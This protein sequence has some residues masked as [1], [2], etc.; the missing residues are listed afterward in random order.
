MR[1]L[2][3]QKLR[4]FSTGESVYGYKSHPVGEL[5][6]NKKGQP[7]YEGMIH[8]IYEEEAAVVRRIYSDFIGGKSINA[9]AQN[10]NENRI[11]T[12]KKLT[13]G[14]NTSTVSRIL[15]NE[16]YTGQC[17]VENG[18]LIEMKP[19]YMAYTNIQTLALL[20]ETKGSNWLQWRKR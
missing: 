10:L 18:R 6:L 7:K 19:F 13:G 20:D 11:P 9:I 15:K 8:K 2:E 17:V 12:R 4:G 1:G 16:K 5:R 3:G 14:W